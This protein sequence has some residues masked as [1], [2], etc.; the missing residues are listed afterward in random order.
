MVLSNQFGPKE[1]PQSG[2]GGGGVCGQQCCI[3]NECVCAI[4]YVRCSL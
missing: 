3:G 4:H 1:C 2:G